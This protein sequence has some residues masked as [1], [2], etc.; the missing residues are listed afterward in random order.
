MELRRALPGWEPE[1]PGLLA[2][3]DHPGYLEP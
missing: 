1:Q 2:D 3:M